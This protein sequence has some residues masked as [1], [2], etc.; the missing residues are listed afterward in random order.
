MK[1]ALVILTSL[2][3]LVFLFSSCRYEKTYYHNRNGKVK[4]VRASKTPPWFST[5]EKGYNKKSRRV[6][7]RWDRNFR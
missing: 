1:K 3:C 7:K 5:R 2:A 6:I 4:H